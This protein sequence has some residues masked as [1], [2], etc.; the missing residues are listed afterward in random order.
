MSYML[1]HRPDGQFEIVLN[2]PILVGI[3]PDEGLA[4]KVMFF[5]QEDDEEMVEDS[6]ASFGQALRDTRAV[7]AELMAELQAIEVPKPA[8][9]P[10]KLLPALISKLKAPAVLVVS[11]RLTEDQIDAAFSRIDAGE[12]LAKVAADFGLTMGQMRSLRGQQARKIQQHLADGGKV[13]CQMCKEKF[14]P[15]L[16]HP[17]TCARCSRD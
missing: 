3:F 2:K 16:S 15:S 9:P 13:I 7:E 10:L 12:A 1:R 11:D 6:T 4:S 14:T 17:D 8:A 5:L